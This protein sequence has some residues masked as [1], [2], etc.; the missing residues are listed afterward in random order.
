M[1]AYRIRPGAG[2]D[3]L[4][5][6]ER[7]ARP[8]RQHELRVRIRAVSLNF[9]DVNTARGGHHKSD[10]FVVPCSDG[11]GEVVEVGPDVTRF[12]VGD[13]VA[14]IFFPRWID[15]DPTPEKSR[16]ARWYSRRGTR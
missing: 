1:N 6:F 15:G 5:K 16:V 10:H 8:P 12:R 13:R 11:A 2:I 14:G 4:E 7:E 3:A 9:R